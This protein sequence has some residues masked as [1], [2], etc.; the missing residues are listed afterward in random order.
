MIN[1]PIRN[2][3]E[4]I[5]HFRVRELPKDAIAAERLL[6]FRNST[7]AADA[8]PIHSC[9]HKLLIAFGIPYWTYR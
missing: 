4:A 2:E 8:L 9:L 6:R 5:K 7:W 1:K 3:P